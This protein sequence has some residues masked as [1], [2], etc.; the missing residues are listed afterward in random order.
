LFGLSIASINASNRINVAA[1]H[2]AGEWI[3]ECLE[4]QPVAAVD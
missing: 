4:P 3:A 2:I 1:R